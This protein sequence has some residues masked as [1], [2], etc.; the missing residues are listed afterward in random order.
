MVVFKAFLGLERLLYISLEGEGMQIGLIG[1][2]SSGKSTFFKAA[3]L[4][5]VDIA[6]FPFTTIKPN[7]GVSYVKI[8]CVDKD[9]EVTCDPSEGYCVEG[10]R[11]VPVQLIDVAGLVP[12]AHEGKG[13]GNQFLSDLNMAD[14]LIHVIDVSGGTNDKGEQVEAGSYDPSNTV[15]FLE[16][17]LDLWYLGI[18]KKGWEKFARTLEHQRG[19]IAQQIAKQLSGLKVTEDMVKESIKGFD[20]NPTSWKEETLL[21]LSTKLR[22]MSKP[23]VI[24]ANK[25]DVEGAK[26][27]FEKLQKAFPQHM[28]IPCSAAGELALREAGKKEVIHYI[29]GEDHFAIKGEVT[30]MQQKGLQVIKEEVLEKYKTTGVQ[31]VLNKAVFDVLAYITVFPGGMNK[32]EDKDGNVLP[33][34]FL[35]PK[36]STALQFAFRLHSDIGNNFVKAMD[37]KSK[38]VIGKE[39]V[40]KDRDVI[41]IMVKK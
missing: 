9:F 32:L 31:D 37:V 30:E 34:C 1:A 16:K 15:T 41:E 27:N 35:L 18:L 26:E 19:N 10:N 33:D 23:I 2:P 36:G 22:E 3:T 12:G 4:A 24:A 11:F 7:T 25:I 8:Q 17:E 20:E 6:N 29:P 21:A 14:V 13:M 28:I 5:E 39:H 40:L 38:K